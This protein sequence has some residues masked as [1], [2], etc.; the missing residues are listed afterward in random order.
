M[1]NKFIGFLEAVGRDFKKA[2][3]WIETLGEAAVATF[4]P[5]LG[6]LFNQTVNAVVTAE[7]AAAAV[8]QQ[9][10]SGVAKAASVVGLMGPLISQ[11]LTDAGQASDAAAVQKYIAAIVTILNTTPAPVALVSKIAAEP[12]WGVTGGKS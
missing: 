3:P 6:P 5:G 9:T 2:L 4:L 11:A 12:A 8:G 1:A 7:Q 10:G